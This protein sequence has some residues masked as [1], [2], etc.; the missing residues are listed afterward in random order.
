MKLVP[1]RNHGARFASAAK[2]RSVLRLRRFTPYPRLVSWLGCAVLVSVAWTPS[3][4]TAE[5]L[6]PMKPALNWKSLA[7]LPDREGF[8]SPFV[9]VA[10]GALLVAGGANFPDKRPWDGGTKIWYDR[11]Y[12]LATPAGSWVEAGRL[13]RANAYG[14]AVSTPAGIICA[15]GGDAKE[16]FRDVELMTW[17]GRTLGRRSLPPLP[18]ACAFGSGALV[19][20]I[21]Y[22]AGG[23]EKPDAT[24]ALASF[25][26]L[27]VT[28]LESGWR[29][30]PVWP[31]AERML[32]VAGASADTF[33]LFGGVALSAGPD[34]KALRRILRDAY[35][36][37]AAQG[38]MKLA[39]LPRAATA[40]PSPAPLTA[41]GKLLVI[42]GD[43]GLRAHLT[44]PDHPGFPTDIWAYDPKAKTWSAADNAPISRATVPTVLWRGGWI[45]ASGERKPGYR[46]PEI[47]WLS[48][49]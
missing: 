28:K 1:I 18:R 13:P 39:D 47:W 33:Y 36:Y 4:R 21:F 17:D 42:S 5:T 29:E 27:D 11:V 46:S 23:I 10:G 14:V 26:A 3:A 9:G 24:T 15:G 16:N 41:D 34:G 37:N 31:G 7:P 35:A 19:G 49:P 43:D 32:A 40:A 38:W 8:A 25:W 44:G 30:L 48:V 2:K 12:A 20:N 6:L 22:L 45:M